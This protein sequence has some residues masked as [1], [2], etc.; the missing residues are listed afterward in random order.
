MEAIILEIFYIFLGIMLILGGANYLTDGAASIA[1]HF[2]ISDFVI[3][4]T[5]VALGTSMP[6]MVTSF[7]SAVKGNP[8]IAIGNIVGSNSFNTLVVVGFCALL[9]P[10]TV[11][12][13]NIKRDIPMGIGVSTILAVATFGGVINRLEG[14]LMLAIYFAMLYYSIVTS[15]KAEKL[16]EELQDE[17]ENI[18]ELSIP[19][20]TIMTICGLVA[21]VFGGHIFINN[22]VHIAAHYNISSKVIAVTLVAGATSLPE[23]A[24]SVVSLIKGKADIALGN[25]IGSNIANILLVLGASSLFTPLRMQTISSFDIAFILLSS[26]LLWIACVTPPQKQ[27]SRFNAILFIVIYTIYIYTT[28]K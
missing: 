15:R 7:V 11:T 17:E 9:T 13:H 21:L 20:S 28:I 10:M 16:K 18:K 12:K 6:E 27:I 8:D 23:F 5:I 1:K 25:I 19:V 2:K 24:A 4:L 26:I 14:G 3:G 22:A